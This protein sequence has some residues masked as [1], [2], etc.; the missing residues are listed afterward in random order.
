MQIRSDAE[1][2]EEEF[3]EFMRYSSLQKEQFRVWNV[4]QESQLDPT[5]ADRYDALFVGGS[6][7][8]PEDRV[9]FDVESFPFIT[10]AK[11]LVQYCID[12][13]IPT[14]ASCIGF[15]IA[16]EV[17]GGEI[18]FDKA[19]MEMGTYPIFLTDAGKSDPLF[20]GIPAEFLAV[21]GHKKRA[22]AVPEGCTLLAYSDLCPIHA[23]RI[24]G[25]PFYAFQFHPEL[26]RTDLVARL[27]RY[28]S[29][30]FSNDTS[31]EA[32]KHVIDTCQET[33][34]A[35][36]LLKWFVDRILLEA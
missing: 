24:K 33:P 10:S 21:A 30:Y 31:V 8:D 16:I 36:M 13:S 29:R 15:Q 22:R 11:A 3:A 26:D 25:K 18:I 2:A 20:A 14:F 35:N 12:Q 17:L 19:H 27:T 9:S 5:E 28:L 23:I 6:S 4:F 1:T 7:D 34:K 32:L